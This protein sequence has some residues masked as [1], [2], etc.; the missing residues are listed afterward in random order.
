MFVKYILNLYL[1]FSIP[2]GWKDNIVT[3]YNA[4]LSLNNALK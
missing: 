1:I 2:V 3:N 4:V